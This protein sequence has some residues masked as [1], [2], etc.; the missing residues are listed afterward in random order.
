MPVQLWICQ[1]CGK[2]HMVSPI[3]LGR[4]GACRGCKQQALIVNHTHD[5]AAQARGRELREPVKK[6]RSVNY[7]FNGKR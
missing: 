7:R 4:F 6:E 3:Q 1:A 2:P 5:Q